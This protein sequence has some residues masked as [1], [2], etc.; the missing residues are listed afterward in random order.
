MSIFVT[1]ITSTRGL[2]PPE[3]QMDIPTREGPSGWCCSQLQERWLA[4]LALGEVQPGWGQ[5]PLISFCHWDR[6]Q[7]GCCTGTILPAY[8][9]RHSQGAASWTWDGLG[10]GHEDQQPGS[11]LWPCIPSPTCVWRLRHHPS[12]LLLR[13]GSVSEATCLWGRGAGDPPPPC[14]PYSLNAPGCSHLV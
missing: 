8:R 3:S 9:Q 13:A 10:D 12:C 11:Y 6:A 7:A 14:I 4:A 5:V 1:N 2:K